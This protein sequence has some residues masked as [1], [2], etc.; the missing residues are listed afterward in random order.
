MSIFELLRKTSLTTRVSSAPFLVLA[1]TIALLFLAEQQSSSSLKAMDDIHQSAAERRDRIG[2]LLAIAYAVHSDVSRHLALVESG[3][4]EAKLADILKAI[5]RRMTEARGSVAGLKGGAGGDIIDD[6]DG[7]FASYAKAVTQMND[8]AQSDRLIAIPLMSHVDKQFAELAGRI[9]AAQTAIEAAAVADAEATRVAAQASS[10]RFW[11]LVTAVLTVF[12]A[13]TL[14]VVRS[15]TQPLGNL[16]R[17]MAA[18]SQGQLDIAVDG[19]EARDEVG[20]MARALKVFKDNALEA[21]ELRRRQAR[22]AQEAEA[23]K[24]AALARMAETIEIQAQEAV[25]SVAGRTRSMSGSA[26]AMEASAARVLDKATSVAA[27]AEQSLSNAQTVA[28]AAEELTASIQEI[29]SQVHHSAEITRRAVSTADSTQQTMTALADAVARISD[30]AKLINDIAG[31]TNLL[32]LNAT[33]EAA[34]AGDAG[35]GFAVVANEVKN[36]ASQTSKS[37]EEI[38]RQISEIR[39]VT[40]TSVTSVRGIIDA[41]SEIGQISDSIA[42]A[43]EEQGAAT[44]EIARNIVQTTAAAQEVSVHIAEVSAEASGT[45]EH[46]GTVRAVANEV[47]ESVDGLRRDLVAV[48]ENALKAM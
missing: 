40:D 43:I 18:L 39:A 26:E 1:L 36:L 20:A 2:D 29:G 10:R 17:T 42:A 38:A 45:G 6:I 32:A 7:R 28:A 47:A 25:G 15:I 27:A 9:V 24:L 14:L 33:I 16:T 21:D 13:M 44:S 46:A 19:V 8:M 30:V 31:Q 37:T 4:S 11:V 34:R 48:V 5:D 3:T 22:L 35:K 41:I 12:I 23:E